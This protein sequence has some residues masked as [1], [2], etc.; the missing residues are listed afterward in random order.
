MPALSEVIFH[1]CHLLAVT[2]ARYRRRLARVWHDAVVVRVKHEDV[3]GHDY[4]H[5][6]DAVGTV[7]FHGR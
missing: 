1:V 4:L 3:G 6:P 2:V 7:Y 5:R